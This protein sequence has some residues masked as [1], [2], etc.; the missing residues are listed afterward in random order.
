MLYSVNGLTQIRSLIKIYYRYIICK[1]KREWIY[2]DSIKDYLFRVN[3]RFEDYGN[4][5]DHEIN[6]IVPL[7]LMK[8]DQNFYNYVVSSNNL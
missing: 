4:T 8:N 7:G 3:E 1:W 5:S 6:E 2:T